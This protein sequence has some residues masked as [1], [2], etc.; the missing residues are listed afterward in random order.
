MAGVP[1]GGLIQPRTSANALRGEAGGASAS[2]LPGQQL[3]ANPI[4]ATELH[5]TLI[6]IWKVFEDW[7]PLPKPTL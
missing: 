3:D 1:R 4:T 2:Q 6:G 7:L 5:D